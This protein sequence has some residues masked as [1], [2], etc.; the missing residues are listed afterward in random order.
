MGN[1]QC[2]KL[3]SGEID[4]LLSR[5]SFSTDRI[6]D[7]HRDFVREYPSGRIDRD[8]FMRS[9]EARFPQGDR[10]FCDLL[11]RAHDSDGNGEVSFGEFLV[12]LNVAIHGNAEDKLRWA[13][14]MYDID[15]D[16]TVSRAEVVD[17]LKVLA[18]PCFIFCSKSAANKHNVEQTVTKY[19][20]HQPYTIVQKRGTLNRT[21]VIHIYGIT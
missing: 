3:S 1:R 15:G 16:G 2:K 17:I 19:N 6:L 21:I 9:Y 12:S 5:C 18:A 11:F 4:D 8:S 13:L 7:M 14:R 20:V 10:D